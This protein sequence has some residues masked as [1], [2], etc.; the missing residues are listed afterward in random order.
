M[1]NIQLQ[2]NTSELFELT[3]QVADNGDN[4]KLKKIGLKN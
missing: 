3:H 1:E 2:L 4:E